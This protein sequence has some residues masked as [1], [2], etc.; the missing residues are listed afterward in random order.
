[1]IA[2]REPIAYRMASAP[3]EFEQIHRLNYR[4]FVEEIPQHHANGAGVLVDR[5]HDENLY[6]IAVRG[7][8]VV[9]MIAVRTTRP[10]S[11]DG[12]L[13][14]LD[15]HLPPGKR[16]C[17]IRLLAIDPD[18]RGGAILRG[19]IAELARAAVARGFTGAVISGTVRQLR[20]YEHIGFLPF[21]PLVGSAEAQ[22]Q[23]MYLTLEAL[24]SFR[25]SMVERGEGRTG[26][27]TS[28]L[29]GPVDIHPSVLAALAEPPVS[30]RAPEFVEELARLREGLCAITGAAHVSVMLGSGTL[31]NDAVAY[32]L[33][34]RGEPGLV[35]ANGEFGERLVDHAGRA[36]L[37]FTVERRGW[38]EPFDAHAIDRALERHPQAR[39]C[40]MVHLETSTSVVNALDHLVER[41]R[42]RGTR[43]AAD[44][45]SAVGSIPVDAS[46]LDFATAVSG[47]GIAALPG[48]AIV[49]HREAV[50]PDLRIPRY[51]DLGLY[52]AGEGV[53]VPFT[54]SSNLLRAL[55]VAVR[56]TLLR[57][58]F[59][60][61]ERL[62]GWLRHEL[63]ARG[64]ALVAPEGHA[65]P[66]IVT[67]A[68][69]DAL[70][71]EAVADA[72]EARGFALSCRSGYLRERNWIQ[73]AIMGECSREKLA[74]MLSAW[75]EE[76][77]RLARTG[78]ALP[79]AV[80]AGVVPGTLAA[81]APRPA[82]AS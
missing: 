63:R 70:R 72:L 34:R 12:K 46:R 65:A 74:A 67:I 44:C 50:T 82:R 69:G 42:D 81:A 54:Q 37:D 56:R 57:G 14:D 53:G 39:W 40:W 79:P 19:L 28:F 26:A 41:A 51:L 64:L 21:G 32:Q 17:E 33:A 59:A 4:T 61:V 15:R 27:V 2:P 38:G 22:Y 10:F 71:V 5:F 73:V 48:V 68:L 6:F 16:W 3:W 52:G 25:V 20:L 1:M 35:F 77:D 58:R 78:R 76:Y 47:K 29:P 75:D 62:A 9:G 45:V 80:A 8:R 23:P 55:G 18:A 49:Y 7:E 66:G 60:D 36:G 11:L 30:H 13:P 43:V 24:R 31:A